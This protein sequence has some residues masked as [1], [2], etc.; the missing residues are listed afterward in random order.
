MTIELEARIASI[1][2]GAAL[3]G[4][5]EHLRAR[6]RDL[7]TEQVG[8]ATRAASRR[9]VLAL[10]AIVAIA[11]LGVIL[12][13]GG[14]SVPPSAS[15]SPSPAPSSG[16]VA[17]PIGA[18]IDGLVI[19]S[20][21]QLLQRRASGAI[22]GEA[23]ALGG[24]WTDRTIPHSCA[25]PV[26]VT[27]PSVLELG[28]HDIEFGITERNEP[29][30]TFLPTDQILPPAGAYLNPYVREELQHSLFS[31]PVIDDQFYPPVPIVVIGHFDDPRAIACRPQARQGC[32]DRFVID[33]IVS[34]DPG[35]VPAPTPTS[36]S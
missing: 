2:K 10:V 4:A 8:R 33:R 5:P 17:P 18:S 13:S 1:L 6:L 7:P 25:V 26:P 11:A 20:V 15:A 19:Q 21:G 16:V 35:S 27:Q 3:P 31:L 34:F 22:K 29:I 14:G 23:V 9:V 32:L 36:G 12:L 30:L 24:W 28:C